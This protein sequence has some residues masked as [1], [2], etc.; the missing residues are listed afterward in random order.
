M[1][2]QSQRIMKNIERTSYTGLFFK[3]CINA[4]VPPKTKNT[5]DHPG[6]KTYAPEAS[7]RAIGI[8]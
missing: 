3:Y 8:R 7:D 1:S 5:I 4:I 2:A 6:L